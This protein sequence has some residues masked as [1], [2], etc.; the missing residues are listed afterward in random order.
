MAD[1]KNIETKVEKVDVDL[2]EIFN[3]APGADSVALPE[4]EIKKPNVFSRKKDVD[5]SFIDKPK[6][7][8][9]EETTTE[10]STDDNSETT[11]ETK[12]ETKKEV[13]SKEQI[14]ELLGDNIPE[15]TEE[16]EEPKKTR[17]RKPIE[18]VGDVFKKLIDDEKLLAFD[19]GKE[20]D[21]YSA[22]D[23]QELIQANLDERANAVRR[24]TPKQFFDSLPQELQIAARY[25]AD[26]G[27]D[28]KGMFGALA[29]VEEHR[30]L[31]VKK[32]NDQEHIIREYL[33][34][35]GFGNA[36]EIQEEIEV[37]KDL[38]K[39][40]QQAMKF[41]P[42]LDK[43]QEK[44]VAQKLKQQDMV[45]KQKE[46]ASKNYMQNVYNSLKDGRVGSIK[47]DKKTQSF[48]YNGLVNPSY[49]SISGQNTNLLGHLLE[50]YQ[51]VE[52]NYPLVTEALWLLADPKGYKNN[53]MKMGANKAV[54]QTVRK[55]KT[56]QSSKKSAGAIQ[57]EQPKKRPSRKLPRK[58]SNIFKRI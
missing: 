24:E 18:G 28:L 27:T 14:D 36:E 7:E 13:V 54:E 58:S 39:L 37:W 55:L 57:E 23:W 38:G 56:A 48:I 16:V 11:E 41:K 53:I 29:Q 9:K 22:K 52:P 12:Q 8:S 21:E 25:V 45:R 19:D 4:E 3:G 44:V 26:G 47:V 15:E 49:P 2:S 5:M 34:A 6:V 31:D 43:M 32:E 46:Q 10:E 33:G 17:G 30:A 50:K 1:T 40:E 35:T 42:K 51:F 20:I